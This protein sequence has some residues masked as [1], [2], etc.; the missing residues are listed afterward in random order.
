MFVLATPL[1]ALVGMLRLMWM[2]MP[3]L[4]ALFCAVVLG[5]LP[6][7]YLYWLKSQ[8]IAKFERQLPE[9][10]ELVSRALRAGHA[11][12]VGL[13]LVGDE[14]GRSNRQGVSTSVR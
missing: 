14:V 4:L 12:S 11:F 3:V 9:A 10:L 6:A 13:K 5:S 8:R 7:M 2:H 1:L